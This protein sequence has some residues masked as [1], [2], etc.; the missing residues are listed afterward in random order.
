MLHILRRIAK[1]GFI[2]ISAVIK[3]A[4]EFTGMDN[5]PIE[6]RTKLL[7]DKVELY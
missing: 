2:L 6:N 3:L 7:T 1:V 5:V 4:C